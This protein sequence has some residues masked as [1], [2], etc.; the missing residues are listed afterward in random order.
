MKT[1]FNILQTVIN[2]KYKMYPDEPFSVPNNSHMSEEQLHIGVLI[3]RIYHEIKS[4]K[5]VDKYKNNTHSKF[6]SLNYIL[7]NSFYSNE[8]KEKLFDI[9]SKAQ[10]HYFAFSRLSYIYKLNKYKIVV[11]DDLMLNSLD[12]NHENTFILIDNK[13]KYLFGLNDLITIIETAI[14]NSPNFFSE[15]LFPNNPYNKQQ[16]TISTLYNIYFKMKSSTRVIS[17]L[18]HFFFLDEFNLNKFSEHYEPFIRENSIKKYVFNSHFTT[19][20]S[21][22]LAMLK[23]N[24]YTRLYS[25]HKD[26]PKETLVDIFRP[27][28]FYYYIYNYDIKG[29]SKIYNYKRI[30]H[31]KLKAFYEYN[32]TFGRRF[33]KIT[34]LLNKTIKKEYNYNSEHI[35][36]YKIPN[37]NTSIYFEPFNRVTST[38]NLFINNNTNNIFNVVNN[39]YENTYNDDTDTDTDDDTDDDTDTHNTNNTINTANTNEEHADVDY[40][41]EFEE[42]S[43]HLQSLNLETPNNQQE[44]NDDI[45]DIDDEEQKDDDSIS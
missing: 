14:G 27:F 15:P 25:I 30:L 34:R 40:Q 3:N 45:D 18:F 12:I 23:S 35:S 16:L 36:F 4:K 6:S 33:I 7:N 8:L 24:P 10:K 44:Q 41:R 29:T 2:Q 32:K 43:N 38:I 19:L 21:G 17:T 1:F 9:F 39:F 5:Y 11:S 13:S 26:F 31:I 22:V 28:L 37:K 20:H 42:L